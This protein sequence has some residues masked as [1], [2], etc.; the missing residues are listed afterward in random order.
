[1]VDATCRRVERIQSSTSRPDEDAA[2]NE[3]GLGLVAA[4][5]GK[6]ESPF[7][8][9]LGNIFSVKAGLRLKSGIGRLDAPSV[10]I[11]GA[12]RE[13]LR[14]AGA[15]AGRVGSESQRRKRKEEQEGTHEDLR[16]QCNT[17]A[18]ALRPRPR[19]RHYNDR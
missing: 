17:G 10:P 5:A 3:C 16:R 6:S 1:P 8:L 9:E 14:S 12:R 18:G 13:R 19:D 2:A 11:A 4:L 7:E 15:P